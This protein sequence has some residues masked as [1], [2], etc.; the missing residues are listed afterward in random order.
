MLRKKTLIQE[1][2]QEIKNKKGIDNIVAD[3]LS[4]IGSEH[5]AKEGD[6]MTIN[7]ALSYEYLMSIEEMSWYAH[8]VNY[9][10]AKSLHPVQTYQQRK[11]FFSKLKYYFWEKPFLFKYYADQIIR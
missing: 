11:K 5:D 2:D 7:D 6:P 4:M 8:I 3:H 1:F 9:L 10:V